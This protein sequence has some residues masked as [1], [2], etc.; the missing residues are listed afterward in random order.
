MKVKQPFS[1]IKQEII[2]IYNT[3]NQEIFGV[4]VRSQKLEILNDKIIITATHKRIPALKILDDIDRMLT[5]HV[6]K[7]LTDS[8]KN[9]L[10]QP[11]E[12]IVGIPIKVILKDYDPYTEYSATLIIFQN[13]LEE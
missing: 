8:N 6:D 2:K 1:I 13:T 7:A 9:F 10:K 4:G 11:I 5:T 12:D 3:V